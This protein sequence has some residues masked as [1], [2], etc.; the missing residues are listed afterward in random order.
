MVRKWDMIW[1]S[2][3]ERKR[4]TLSITPNFYTAVSGEK[5][6]Y[7]FVENTTGSISMPVSLEYGIDDELTITPDIRSID[8][9]TSVMLEDKL[10][11]DMID[12]RQQSYTFR[13]L[14]AN[15]PD[16]FV[17]HLSLNNSVG[18]R[19]NPSLQVMQF[20]LTPR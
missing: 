6:M 9:S 20:S 17:L 16:R 5:F 13:H 7:N 3:P 4:I 12:L 2:M 18:V 19:E 10:S 11:G 14:A 1:Q 8:A 15:A